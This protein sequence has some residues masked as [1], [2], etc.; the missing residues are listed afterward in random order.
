MITNLTIKNYA[1]IE[2]V[3]INFNKG[4]T[5]ITGETGAGKSIIMDSI[6]LLLGARASTGIIRMGT[7]SCT[8]VGEFD[9][10]KNKNVKNIL[11]D[12]SVE[13]G[14]EIIVRRQIDISGKSKA[15]IN[16][17]PVTV[18]TLTNIGKYLVDFYAQHKSNM[19]FERN[20][21]R[22]IIDE[23]ADNK[24]LLEDLFQKFTELEKLRKQKE[25]IEKADADRERLTDLYKYQIKEITEAGLST[26]EEKNIE[27]E[28]PKLKNAEKIKNVT[29][30]IILLI[31][32]KENSVLDELSLINK[33]IE[34]LEKYG[35]NVE[36]IFK[37]LSVSLSAAE[38]VY[39]EIENLSNGIDVAPEALD[40]MLNRQQIIKKLKSKYG[41]TIQDI[42][43][44]LNE[45]E[46]KLKTLENYEYNIEC[47]QKQIDKVLK[48][49]TDLCGK[50]SE[51]RKKF[52]EIISA[53]VTSELEDLNLKNA[54][55]EIS[56]EKGEITSYGFD[57]IQFMFSANRGEKIYPLSLVASGGEISRVML[58]LSAA[59]SEH[60]NVD[61]IIFDE[62]DTGTSGRTGDKIGKKLKK[63]SVKRQ[64]ISISHLAQIAA[65]ADNHIKIYKQSENGRNVTGA[66]ILNDKE[67]IEEIAKIISGERVTEF[68]LKHAQ[69]MIKIGEKAN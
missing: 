29:S 30:E 36:N 39:A 14:S 21:Q 19:L 24:N 32:K 61:T 17:I 54:Q 40:N 56:F 46:T 37:N 27:Q 33:Q 22:H 26:E 3:N 2:N 28:L 60:Y 58:A 67:R 15:Y 1:L 7:N 62:I 42:L 35:I 55:F 64:I 10:S 66:K 45:L 12:L 34:Q 16:D 18:N 23:I 63:L 25:E 59:I 4:L 6:D 47:I 5:V 48:E 20:Y 41:A 51:K 13:V 52:A 68:A 49:V 9:I 8:I 38:D 53:K 69:E 65:S 44:Y 31:S 50:I 11:S 43:N 57:K